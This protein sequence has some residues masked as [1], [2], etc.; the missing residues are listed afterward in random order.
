M[1]NFIK[2]TQRFRKVAVW[3]LIAANITLAGAY[4]YAVNSTV[5]NVVATDKAQKSLAYNNA[6]IAELESKYISFSN[7][8]TLDF[9]YAEGYQDASG[10]QIYVPNKAAPTGLSFSAL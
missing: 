6:S 5:F 10:H 1:K 8:L 2:N 7:N 3:L 4:T 9:A